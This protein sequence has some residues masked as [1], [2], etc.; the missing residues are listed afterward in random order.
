M[1][2]AKENVLTFDDRMHDKVKFR[3]KRTHIESLQSDIGVW[4]TDKDSVSHELR[5]HFS[6]MSRSEYLPPGFYQNVGGYR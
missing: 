3:K 6:K 2:R 4:L 5:N 1:Q